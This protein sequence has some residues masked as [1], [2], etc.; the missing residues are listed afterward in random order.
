MIVL[1]SRITIRSMICTSFCL[2]KFFLELV[3]SRSLE[4]VHVVLVPVLGIFYKFS[5]FTLSLSSIL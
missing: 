4:L 1:N 5:M 3:M 2:D